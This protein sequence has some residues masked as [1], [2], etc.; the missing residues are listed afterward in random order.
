MRMIFAGMENENDRY[1]MMTEH[2]NELYAG[3][4][5]SERQKNME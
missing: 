1:R 4:R 3:R 5:E 2:E